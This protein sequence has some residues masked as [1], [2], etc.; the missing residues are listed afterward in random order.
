[1]KRTAFP[2]AAAATALTLAGCGLLPGGGS[3]G[4]PHPTSAA[5]AKPGDLTGG[6]H[7]RAGYFLQGSNHAALDVHRVER[8][9]T[10]SVLYMDV[11]ALGKQTF[12]LYNG[13]AGGLIENSFEA[14][15]LV[16]SVNGKYYHP[17]A[18]PDGTVFGTHIEAPDNSISEPRPGYRYAVQVYYPRLPAGVRQITVATSGTTGEMTGIPVMDAGKAQAAVPKA[19]RGKPRKG[20]PY[21][22]VTQPPRGRIVAKVE[23]LHG[24]T[25][26]AAKTTTRD[27]GQ[28]KLALRTDVLFAFDKA[29][30]SSKAASVLDDAIDQTRAQADPAKPPITITGFTDA[31]GSDAYN[32]KLSRRRAEAVQRY[33]SAKLGGAYRYQATGKGEA[34]PVAANTHDDGS[35]DP[36]GRA[37]NRRVEIGYKIKQQKPGVTTTRTAT[38][39][40]GGV[41]APAA[42]RTGDGPVAGSKYTKD[43]SERV[44]VHPFYRDGAY[45][46]G[47]LNLHGMG[48]S[49]NTSPSELEGNSASDLTSDHAAVTDV[50]GSQFGAAVAFDQT[51]KTAYY[52]VRRGPAVG[53]SSDPAT[54]V[55]SGGL[56]IDGT[57]DRRV[58]VYYPAPPAGVTKMDLR[59][60]ELGTVRNVPIQ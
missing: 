54:Y 38:P 23:D 5:S 36:A 35:D 17:L 59:L 26:G 55:E 30:L 22:W 42:W 47:V 3:S 34:N 7:Y 57:T 40:P 8:Y 27:G 4:K 20:Q 19:T 50:I 15:G 2:A 25:E 18:A 56:G 24:H 33:I 46:V 21:F 43:D 6:R 48:G 45:L 41:S 37:K 29:N 14:F 1:M 51:G 39:R 32:L 13:V 11:Y 10:Y 31:K 60:G 49:G 9:P 16:D 58:F 53:Q 52:V 28:E 12:N 44:D